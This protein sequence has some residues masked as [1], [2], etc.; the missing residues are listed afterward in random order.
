MLNLGM[1][2]ASWEPSGWQFPP[3]RR[4]FKPSYPY[5]CNMLLN[6]TTSGRFEALGCDDS[7]QQCILMM[8]P[9]SADAGEHQHASF[10]CTPTSLNPRQ[11]DVGGEAA[12]R[13]LPA[14]G[15]GGD[16]AARRLPAGGA[17]PV[18]S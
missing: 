3:S 6:E 9:D 14:D 7:S 5:L 16:D 2:D 17:L 15:A 10:I 18:D 8:T 13:Q 1:P 12:A 4:T 11:G